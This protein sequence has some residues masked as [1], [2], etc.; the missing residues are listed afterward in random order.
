[1]LVETCDDKA[2]EPPLWREHDIALLE[3]ARNADGRKFKVVRVRAPRRRYWKGD[4]DTFAPCYLNAYV[5]NGAVIGARF[6]DS[7]ARRGGAQGACARHFPS[8]R[9]S[10][11]GSTISPMGGG[12]RSLPDA[13]DA[14]LSNGSLQI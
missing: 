10:C 9:L 13:A 7:R 12:G 5:A 14:W 8:A 11:C 4:P 1:M 2:I 3:N 6:G